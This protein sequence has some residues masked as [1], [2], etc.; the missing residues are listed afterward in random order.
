VEKQLRGR[1]VL[2]AKVHRT[3]HVRPKTDAPKSIEDYEI[4]VD[5]LEGL[6][7]EIFEGT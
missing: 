4:I 2:S 3:L 1:T 5:E 7:P 6:K